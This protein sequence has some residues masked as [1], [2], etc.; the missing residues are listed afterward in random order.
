MPMRQFLYDG[1]NADEQGR[2][3][4]DGVLSH[5]ASAGRL[6]FFNHR[7]ASPTRTNG[8]HEEH[9]FP[10]DMFPFTYGDESDPYAE[11][12]TTDGILRKARATK[13][14]PK[15]MHTQSSSEYWHRSGSLVHTDPLSQRDARIPDEVR[16]YAL[17]GGFYAAWRGQRAESRVRAAALSCRRILPTIAR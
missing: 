17:F 13:T 15:V 11:T 12:S 3:A 16:I 2:P 1:F 8:Q 5:V 9:S 4:F 10:A 6:G 14:V 7:F